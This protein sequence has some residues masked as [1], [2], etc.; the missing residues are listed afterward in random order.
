MTTSEIIIFIIQLLGS[1]ALFLFGMTYMSEA[2]QRLAGEKLRSIL[3]KFTSN[4]IK[5]I[6]TGTLVTSAIQSSSATTVMVVSFVN[7]GLLKLSNAIGVIMGANIGTTITGWIIAFLGIKYDIPSIPIIG[8]G[9]IFMLFK[10]KRTKNLGEFLV[11]FGLLFLGLTF[12]KETIGA[13]DFAN[14]ATILSL[15]SNVGIVEGN[16]IG[17]AYILFFVLIGTILTIILQSSSAMMA[18]TMLLCAQGAI[19]SNIAFEV[20][21]ALVLGENIGTTIT[22]NLAAFVGNSSAKR[23][24]RSHLIFN[25]I[26]VLWIL[27]VFRPFVFGVDYVATA[28][29]GVSPYTSNAAIPIALSLF[30]TFFN[31]INTSVLAW[32]IPQIEKLSSLLVKN[33]KEEDDEIFKLTYI[34]AGIMRTGELEL[35]SAKKEIQVFAKRISRMFDFIPQLL[36]IKDT[37]KYHDLLKRT[38]HYEDIADKMEFEIANYLTKISNDGLGSES[39]MRIG[40]MLRIVDNLESIGDQN[41]QLAKMIYNKNEQNISFTPEMQNNLSKMFNLVK[42]SINIMENNLQKNYVD[43][44]I[45]DALKK[46]IEIN[47]YRN[48]L[49]NNHIE[50][51]ENKTYNYQTG[52]IYSGMYAL[53]EKIG[54]HTIN[55]SEALVNAKHTKDN[56]ITSSTISTTDI[57]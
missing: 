13:I 41:F 30:H 3:A 53:L 15:F 46:E 39:A 56:S 37:K 1:L 28:M 26:G 54:D 6:L 7:A 16:H 42:E 31:I 51:L 29:E 50:N 45:E 36:E 32:F 20:A 38:E 57:D 14:N 8:L 22:A 34:N 27:F 25:V 9:F 35:E 5:A 43:V 48:S 24:A 52:I 10:N 11:G 12:L 21:V 2:L 47:E 33:T 18:L 49:R 19:P 40:G 44:E 23:A 17:Y 55:I 4:R